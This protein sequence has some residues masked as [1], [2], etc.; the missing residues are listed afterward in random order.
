MNQLVMDLPQLGSNSGK[1]IDEVLSSIRSPVIMADIEG[2]IFSAAS[3]T[4]IVLGFTPSELK[5]E[6]L[7]VI[8]TPEDLIFLYPNLL[9]M[10]R[11][12]RP[13]EGEIMLLR[14]DDSRFYAF[15]VLRTYIE[16]GLDNPIIIFCI[17]DIDRLKQLEKSFTRTP[18][19]DLVNVANGIAHELRNP[20]TGIGGFVSRLYKSCR[21]NKDHDIYYEYIINNLQRIENLVKKVEY[22]ARLPKPVFKPESIRRLVEKVLQPYIPKIRERRIDLSVEVEEITLFVDA[23]LIIRALSALVENSL[24]AISDGEKRIRIYSKINTDKYK[25]Y[26]ADTGSGVLPDDLPYILN[27]FFSTK[28]E[29]AGIDLA[30]TKRIMDGHRGGIEVKSNQGEDT[31]FLLILPIER[32][33]R[34]RTSRFKD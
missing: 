27:P 2:N 23:D 16:P 24:D 4:G 9:H 19:E 7:S 34:I 20:L 8:F 10:A 6:N 11:K 31:L 22:F 13:F 1:F 25:I 30:V 33:R 28:P 12:N 26:V 29:G 21:S 5:G 18:Y 32:R 3:V 14:K 15:V 17:Q